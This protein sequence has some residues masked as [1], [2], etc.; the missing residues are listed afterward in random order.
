MVDT[1]SFHAAS[2]HS[3]ATLAALFNRG[4]AGYYAPVTLDA[5]A[6]RGMVDANQI[7]LDASYVGTRGEEPVAFAMLG[8]RG[9]RGWIGGMGVVPEARGHGF[10]RAAMEAAL[11]SARQRGLQ[12]VDLEVLEQNTPAYRIYEALEFRDRRKVEVF[13]RAPAPLPPETGPA[14]EVV[15]LAVREC[16][17]RHTALHAERA[18]W[19]RDLPALEHWADRL[20]ALG[21]REGADLG[22]WVLYRPD[23]ARL[24]LADLALAAG[25]PGALLIATLRALI[26]AHPESTLT[27]VNLPADDPVGNC[28]R[29]LGASVKFRQ[30]EMTLAL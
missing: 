23:G 24:N 20:H 2:H 9:Q 4:Y 6:F 1:L 27:L 21:V 15:S 3:D 22:C 14:A 12:H 11:D 8:I 30:R 17:D 25:R 7:D 10:G 28:L 16:L 19:Q 29:A 13:A 26:G 5:A 18:P